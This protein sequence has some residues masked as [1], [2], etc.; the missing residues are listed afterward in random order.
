MWVRSLAAFMMLAAG[1]SRAQVTPLITALNPSA[2][3]AGAPDL[4]VV[5]TGANFVAGCFAR[6]NGTPLN[7][8]YVSSTQLNARIPANL[9]A[10][11]T[12]ATVTVVNPDGRVSP[13]ASF[14]VSPPPLTITSLALP[15]GMVGMPYSSALTAAGG[16]APY[17]WTADD[18]LPPGLFLNSNGT[19]AGTPAG[20]GEFSFRVR[21]VDRNQSAATQ[22]VSLSISLPAL[23]ITTVSPLPNGTV[24]VRYAQV[25]SAAAGNPPYRWL[26]SGA[27]PD[28]LQ[29]DPGTG[30]LNGTPQTRGNY[31]LSVRVTDASGVSATRSISLTI[32]PP[33]LNIDTQA[34][35]FAGTVG[36]FYSQAFF[37][38]GGVLPYRWAV[39][40]GQ[41]PDGVSLDASAGALTG[42]PN[43][44]GTFTF[45]I[46]VTDSL[47]TTAAQTFSI[48]VD[49]PK[50]TI[51]TVSPLADGVADT[52]YSK[53]FTATGGVPPYTWSSGA[54]SV[55]GLTLNSSTGLLS[56]TTT[57][58]GAFTF[59]VQVQDSAGSTASRSFTLLVTPTPL[60]IS[61]GTQVPDGMVTQ[62]YSYTLSASGGV[63]PYTW[64][65]N[66]LPQ[67]L[68]LSAATGEIRGTPEAAGQ[69]IFTVR[70]MDSARSAVT[71]LFRINIALPRL[72]GLSI[73]GLPDT[74]DPADQ[75]V[76]QVRLDSPYPAPISGQLSLSFASEV[77]AGDATIQF[78]TGGRT[79]PFTIPAGT[80]DA[81]YSVPAIA[82]QTGTVAGTISVTAQ[83][84]AGGVD[85]T[86]SPAPV[87]AAH[88]TRAAPVI[89]SA[90][91]VRNTN[92]FTVQVV[93]FA[94]SREVTQAVLHFKVAP[95]STLQQ[96]EMTLA[97]EP[98]FTS[99]FQDAA[100]SRYGSQFTFTQ[101]FTVQGDPNAVT[102]E[103]LTLGNRLGSTTAPI[104]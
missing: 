11:P 78:S 90:K 65:A 68:E 36:R 102:P 34:P 8:G 71:G 16:A 10:A 13:A 47:K 60:S 76:L 85:V 54:G 12:T 18:P 30:L 33:P 81:V 9:L 56:G 50:L 15:A 66:G 57:T 58:A 69:L 104:Q 84:Q 25:L 5:I 79:V 20:V 73:D 46:Q 51:T 37:A 45:T 28:G 72:S 94:T 97:V 80:V 91:L 27:V 89:H 26:L 14:T 21:V 55:P 93:G 4:A 24:G 38:S 95:G 49:L 59:S 1:Q 101:P 75:R 40:S 23:S 19:V 39:T 88:V 67:G 29:L 96:T 3:T 7:T 61:T 44:K 31:V 62:A 2:A 63:P 41:L 99:W 53:Q 103:S 70:V 52:A 6:W 98:L 17:T 22:T 48:T 42:T 74:V 100:S 87:A 35:L 92:G 32:N 86:P 64:S 83:I 82:V 77:G 43:A